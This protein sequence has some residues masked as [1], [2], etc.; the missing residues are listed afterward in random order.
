MTR[1]LYVE[2]NDDNVYTLKLRFGLLGGFEVLI[3]ENGRPPAATRVRAGDGGR[4]WYT[5]GQAKNRRVV[6]AGTGVKEVAMNEDVFNAS[7]RKFLKALGVTAQREI[8]KAVRHALAEGRL[9]GSETFPA[10]ATVTLGGIGFSH[11][12]NGEIELG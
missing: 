7:I 9:K 1:I 5:T 6:P 2:D 4:R 8:E 11:E 12:V 3:A 10:R